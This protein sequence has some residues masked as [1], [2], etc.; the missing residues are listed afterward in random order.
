MRKKKQ[1]KNQLFVILHQDKN[2]E[3]F[4][5]TVIQIRAKFTGFQL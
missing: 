3:K 2:Y 5:P 1:K 4:R